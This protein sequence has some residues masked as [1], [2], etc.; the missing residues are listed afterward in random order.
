MERSKASTKT[1][2]GAV[3][4]LLP[5]CG[6]AATLSK[7]QAIA[8]ANAVAKKQG[9]ELVHFLA[10]V[11]YFEPEYRHNEWFVCYT[12]SAPSHTKA[13]TFYVI[14]NDAASIGNATLTFGK[15]E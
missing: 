6:S 12:A 13:A 14:L 3:V 8:L 15:C 2:L 1:L 11:A 9:V 4:L 10:P 5:A 7:E